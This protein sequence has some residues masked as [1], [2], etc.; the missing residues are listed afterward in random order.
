MRKNTNG[1]ICLY[2]VF[3][4]VKE[5]SGLFSAFSVNLLRNTKFNLFSLYSVIHIGRKS[6]RNKNIIVGAAFTRT[7]PGIRAVCRLRLRYEMVR[8]ECIAP[9]EIYGK[10]QLA[11]Q[12]HFRFVR[13]KRNDFFLFAVCRVERHS[14]QFLCG[15]A[16]TAVFY[17]R[18]ESD[19]AAVVRQ[20]LRQNILR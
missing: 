12:F 19:G 5:K 4:V 9:R 13:R 14:V 8:P 17:S 7:H 20:A 15:Y 18:T 1:T 16:D 2:V 10:Q 11:A 6:L 3:P